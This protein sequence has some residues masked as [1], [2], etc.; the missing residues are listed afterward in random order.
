MSDVAAAVDTNHWAG[1]GAVSLLAA[2]LAVVVRAPP[3]LLAGVAAVGFEAY[4]RSA[5]APAPSLTLSRELSADAPEPGEEVTVT[6]TVA[7]DGDGLVP[8]L[9]LVDGVPDGLAVEDGPA[10]LGTALRGG[11]RARFRYTVEAVR[12]V[13]EWEPMQAVVRDASGAAERELSVAAEEPTVFTCTPDLDATADLPLRGL[14]T[15]YTGRVPTDVGGAGVEFHGLREYRHGDPLKRVDWNQLARTG[16]LATRQFR[17]ERAA[18]VVLLVDGRTEAYRAP[19]E[20]VENAVERS[21]D[22]AGAVAPALLDAGDRVGLA[23]F[24]P[25][26]CWLAPATGTD[27][28]TRLRQTLAT[29]PA[30]APTPVDGTF[31]PYVRLRRLRRRLSA[32]TQLIV[33]TPLTDDY[34]PT[35]VRRLDAHGHLVTVV[36][37]DPTTDGTVGRQ[38]AAV[39]RRNRMS[40]LRRAGVRVL[41][42]GADSLAVELERAASR[43]GR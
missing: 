15:Q 42:W 5:T 24:A 21:V 20:G 7:H 29:H 8:D 18:T 26:E 27:H 10:R 39:E 17:E 22:A 6:V 2:S 3:L 1:V 4:A 31:Y 41:D 43:W 37:P 19:A 12:G 23:A 32:D 9:R 35:V 25:Q 13:H 28:R 34:M 40:D 38:L 16:E 30:F 36:S 14:T 33:C 11:K